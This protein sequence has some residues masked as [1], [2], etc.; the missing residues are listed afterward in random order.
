MDLLIL[1]HA[2][3]VLLRFIV[4]PSYETKEVA[5]VGIRGI[6]V[7]HGYTTSTQD[8]SQKGR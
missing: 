3:D 1:L 5:I 7:E 8:L 2:D 4:C 6:D